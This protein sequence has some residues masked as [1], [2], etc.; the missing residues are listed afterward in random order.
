MN[1][2]L[3]S[4]DSQSSNGK[5]YAIITICILAAAAVVMWFQTKG[6][7][8]RS[9]DAAIIPTPTPLSQEQKEV[10]DMS[11]ETQNLQIN[12]LDKDFENID[13]DIN[14]LK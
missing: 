8:G 6:E 13:K 7:P 4:P 10:I 9:N 11:N 5:A 12:S 2:N 3:I 14:T 1:P